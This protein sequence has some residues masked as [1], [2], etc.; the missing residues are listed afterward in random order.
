M[1]RRLGSGLVTLWVAA[2]V[3]AAGAC[4]H[5]V[6]GDAPG[7]DP[8]E[9]S[10][11][12]DGLIFGPVDWQEASSLPADSVERRAANAAGYVYVPARSSRC[13]GFLIAAD[14][15][16]T[17][18]HCVPDAASAAGVVVNF[19]FET[20]WRAADPVRCE[21]FL[22][23]DQALDFALLGCEGRPGERFGVLELDEGALS[24]GT[25]IAML[26]QQCDWTTTPD[27]EPTKKLSPGT[28][29]RLWPTDVAHDAD[30][31]G[32]SS[33]GAIL[34]AGTTRVV[35]I[36]K[37][38]SLP[39]PATGH[40]GANYGTPMSAIVPHLRA[41]FPAVLAEAP[42]LPPPTC[43]QLRVTA[44]ATLNVRPQPDTTQPAMGTLQ[45]DEVV[46]RL[47]SASG[48]RV[49]GTTEWHQ[50]QKPGLTGWGSGA[51]TVC[52]P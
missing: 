34:R 13:S 45:F 14:V 28:V 46:A 4:L 35:A 7:F 29:T 44:A 15:V 52:V 18:H 23:A 33:G 40:L 3:V 20:E 1:R 47:Q 51:W 22:G 43:P 32:G 27:C 24:T 2:G 26:H 16:M 25:A 42:P 6:D 48:E 37:S 21:R 12:D 5:E 49:R 17:N 9:A 36:N 39:D 41:H 50:I 10:V 38:H 31:L 19:L 11:L 30:S 8:R